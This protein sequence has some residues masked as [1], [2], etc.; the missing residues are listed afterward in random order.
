MKFCLQVLY[1]MLQ[2]KIHQFYVK[3]ELLS[4]LRVYRK[5][6]ASAQTDGRIAA[7]GPLY[8]G[9]AKS[10]KLLLLTSSVSLFLLFDIPSQLLYNQEVE[11]ES[12][13]FK[14]PSLN[15]WIERLKILPEKCNAS[16]KD[17]VNK[18]NH[19]YDFTKHITTGF[20][21]NFLKFGCKPLLIIT[22]TIALQGQNMAKKEN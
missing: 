18:I 6:P 5:S 15:V 1:H 13:L 10:L 2:I 20:P 14:Y 8:T 19:A 9:I 7:D 4:L 16:W 17:H 11:F 22:E 3:E 12:S 21:P